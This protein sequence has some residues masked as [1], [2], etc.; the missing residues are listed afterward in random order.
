M[1]LLKGFVMFSAA[2]LML[3][4]AW[5]LVVGE[6]PSVSEAKAQLGPV[7]PGP[8]PAFL[9]ADSNGVVWL[10]DVEGYAWRMVSMGSTTPNWTRFQQIFP[11]GTPMPSE[12]TS[13]SD[14]K[15]QFDRN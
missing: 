14:L 8:D 9:T 12:S 7:Y 3:A 6:V 11:P 10:V 2:V 13:I 15:G 1:R 4:V 5:N